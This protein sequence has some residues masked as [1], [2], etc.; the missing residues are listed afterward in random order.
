[1]YRP[2]RELNCPGPLQP[3]PQHRRLQFRQDLPWPQTRPRGCHNLCWKIAAA[4][5]G[6][7][8][9]T[10]LDS[11]QSARRPVDRRALPVWVRA[12]RR[13]AC[14]RPRGATGAS[15][16]VPTHRCYP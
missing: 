2:H 11:Y 15:L 10:L 9:E 8:E 14:A 16:S 4:L 6:Q 1:M 12:R 7:V 13:N 5:K 3:E